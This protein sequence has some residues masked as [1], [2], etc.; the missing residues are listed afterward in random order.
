M[1][2]QA[3]GRGGPGSTLAF[4]PTWP[5]LRRPG[6]SFSHLHLVYLGGWEGPL[7]ADLPHRGSHLPSVLLGTGAWVGEA[8][9]K[10]DKGCPPR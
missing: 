10:A 8:E 1:K 2:A 3:L 5:G 9:I 4:A 6:T 7:Q